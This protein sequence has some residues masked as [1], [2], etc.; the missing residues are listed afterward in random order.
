[1]DVLKAIR[2]RKSI[3]SFERKEMPKEHLKKLMESAQLSPSGH[4][5]QPWKF[6]AIEEQ[7]LKD[8]LIEACNGQEFIANASVIIAGVTNTKLSRYALIDTSI[9]L[10]HIVLEATELGYGSCWIGSFNEDEVKSILA[11][12]AHLK[13]VCLLAIGV[14]KGMPPERKTR[15]ELK[16][17]SFLN[18]YGSEL[19]L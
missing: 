4:N 19:K 8:E 15:K 14:K 10:E 6:I 12:P 5:L 1:M 3:R 9:A 11:I 18:K 16:E 7:K 17:I 13:V 2:E